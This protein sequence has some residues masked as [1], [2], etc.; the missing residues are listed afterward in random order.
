MKP[1]AY[2]INT[3][4]GPVVDEQ[5]LLAALQAGQIAG[6]ALDVYEHEPTL[7]PGLTLLD[8]VI[9]LPHVGSAT[10]ET[11]TRMASMAA[12]NLIAGLNEQTPPNLINPEVF[13]TGPQ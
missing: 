1:S 10:L 2:L 4:R 5:A 12:Q 3:S 7:T 9:L 6:A 13:A 8:N 11:R